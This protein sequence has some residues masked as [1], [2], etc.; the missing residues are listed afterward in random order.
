MKDYNELLENFKKIQK[1]VKDLVDRY[2]PEK[3]EQ[4]IFDKWSLKD[5]LAHLNHWMV[6]DVD[7]LEHLLR[8]EEPFWEPDLEEF[9]RRGIDARK[10]KSWE[11]LYLEFNRLAEKISLLYE[12]LPKGLQNKRFWMNRNETPIKFLEEN[13]SH[14]EG[15]HIPSLESNLE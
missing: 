11:E 3:R 4:I 10:D 5:V 9:N 14:W 8:D 13:I 6:H 15:E 2:P 1:R 12:Q 7:C